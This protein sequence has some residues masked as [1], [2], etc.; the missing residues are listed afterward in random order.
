MEASESLKFERTYWHSNLDLYHK[1]VSYRKPSAFHKQKDASDFATSLNLVP[2]LKLKYKLNRL[3]FLPPPSVVFLAPDFHGSGVMTFP[4]FFS[5]LSHTISMWVLPPSG[6]Q[7]VA[8][9]EQLFLFQSLKSI[10][11]L[12]YS[13]RY[14]VF[15]LYLSSVGVG[16]L[17]RHTAAH[18]EL[19]AY[20]WLY[21]RNN[22]WILNTYLE[23]YVVRT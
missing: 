10:N 2:L 1:S 13:V 7:Q 6:Q 16:S 4:S 5:H 22:N 19:T 3:T 20:C 23:L 21:K 12:H 14:T 18:L 15:S 8:A 11:Y 17:D 9:Q